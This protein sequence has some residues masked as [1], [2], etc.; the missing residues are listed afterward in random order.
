[1]PAIASTPGALRLL[2]V[3]LVARLP[4]AML[5]IGL[6]VH[7]R[8]L[9]GSFA[10][11]GLVAGAFAVALGAGG[12]LLGALVDRRGQTAVL[13]ATALVAGPALVAAAL[14]PA[15]APLGPSSRS[16]PSSASRRRR[17]A[18][19]RGRSSPRCCATARPCAPPTPPSRP[20]SS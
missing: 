2:A 17:S 11:A 8:H 9:T 10:A 15:G 16:R 5:S 4:V 6:L 3:S 19:A 7:A 1:M 13:L 12:P 18:R 20:L 14:L